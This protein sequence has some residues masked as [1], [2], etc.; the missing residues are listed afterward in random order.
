MSFSKPNY[1]DFSFAH[2]G[3]VYR[4]LEKLFAELNISYYLIGANARD[5][6]LYKN[7]IKPSRGTADIDFA[8]MVPDF[9]VYNTIF[10]SLCNLGFRRA[11][12][13]YRLIFDETNTVIDLMPYG[14]I[15]Q[16][17][18]VNFLERDMILSV[19]GFKEVGE[20]AELF[21]PVEEIYSIPVSPVEGIII[22]KLVSWIDKPETRTKDL[23]D[24]GLLLKYAW[25]FYEMEA[26]ENHSDLF[27]DDFEKNKVAARI[28]GRKMKPI[29]A[30]N[31]KLEETIIAV[32]KNST[33]TKIKVENPEITL[34][35]NMDKT[36]EETIVILELIL[37]GISD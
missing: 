27:D 3:A 24:I 28:L 19:L 31:K 5:V 23:E 29:L 11:Q 8:I 9:D 22:L 37:K 33:I 18:T 34:A 16:D 30:Q 12:E 10:D 13:Q 14:K 4:I 25:D 36:I 1:K 35:I 32:L 20:K 26:Y 2:H 21:S 7:G 17:Y 15:E 6:Q